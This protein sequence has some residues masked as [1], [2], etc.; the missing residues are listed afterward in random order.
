MKKDSNSTK[1]G[2]PGKYVVCVKC[3]LAKTGMRNE[4]KQLF[5]LL[6]DT[7]AENI[8]ECFVRSCSMNEEGEYVISK[9]MIHSIAEMKSCMLQDMFLSHC[10]P[11]E[12]FIR[13]EVEQP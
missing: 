3:D 1:V 5:D 13:K 8:G 11:L 12:S 10:T 4:V 7:L 2:M 6:A 9:P